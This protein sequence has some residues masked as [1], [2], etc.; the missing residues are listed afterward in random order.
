MSFDLRDLRIDPTAVEDREDREHG[1]SSRDRAID[2]TI[3]NSKREEDQRR[4]RERKEQ[5]ALGTWP[6]YAASVQ[7]IEHGGW[8]AVILLNRGAHRYV[9]RE[10]F[11]RFATVDEAYDAAERWLARETEKTRRP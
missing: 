6:G 9:R 11:A 2:V 5:I 1:G 8:I 4:I 10:S 7:D 3:R